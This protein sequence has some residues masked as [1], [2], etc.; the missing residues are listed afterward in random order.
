MTL[1]TCT[2]PQKA[3]LGPIIFQDS[4]FMFY[5][6]CMIFQHKQIDKIENLPNQA[7]STITD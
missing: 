4:D 1:W 3:I 5:D 2:K 6:S 7:F